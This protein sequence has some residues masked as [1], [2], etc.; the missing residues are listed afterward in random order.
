MS[1][2]SKTNRQK[3]QEHLTAAEQWQARIVR[4]EQ[5][6]QARAQAKIEQMAGGRYAT[7]KLAREGIDNPAVLLF[8]TSKELVDDVLYKQAVSNRNAHETQ[9]QMYALAALVDAQQQ[10]ITAMLQTAP[11]PWEQCEDSLHDQPHR[12]HE[13]TTTTGQRLW[14]QGA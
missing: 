10:P 9:A 8:H 3:M 6:A 2:Q 14:C 4:F 7:S 1:D 11:L 12:Q 13:W 5:A